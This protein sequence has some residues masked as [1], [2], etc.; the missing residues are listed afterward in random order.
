MR[1]VVRAGPLEDADVLGLVHLEEWKPSLDPLKKV[2]LLGGLAMRTRKPPQLLYWELQQSVEAHLGFVL[3]SVLADTLPVR[4][5]PLSLALL[6][7]GIDVELAG[8]HPLDLPAVQFSSFRLSQLSVFDLHFLHRK[9]LQ[10]T[11]PSISQLSV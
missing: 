5:L 11:I 3:Q 8:D 10:D 9:T 7:I 6:T 1:L 4:E 2:R